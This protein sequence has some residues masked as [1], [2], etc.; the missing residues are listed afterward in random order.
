[1]HEP[2]EPLPD[3]GGEG[4]RAHDPHLDCPLADDPDGARPDGVPVDGVTAPGGSITTVGG[5]LLLA[6]DVG[7]DL[8]LA[9]RAVDRP[10]AAV[11]CVDA[12]R[13][14][15]IGSPGLSLLA[16]VARVRGAG[17]PLWASRAALRPLRLT[18]LDRLFDVRPAG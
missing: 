6:G 10:W 13:V 7:T 5:T 4:A 14:T 17:V 12:R 3:A 18:G 11:D 9:F 15:F 1:M 2:S 8:C 16:E